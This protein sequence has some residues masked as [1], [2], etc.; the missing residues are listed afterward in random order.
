ME[1]IDLF[2][3]EEKIVFNILVERFH[4]TAVPGLQENI[5]EY[6]KLI[7]D[8]AAALRQ[9]GMLTHR[10]RQIKTK[11]D[12][13]KVCLKEGWDDLLKDMEVLENA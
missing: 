5:E 9:N 7:K 6:K 4:D 13:I 2:K 12:L 10:G 8:Y 1:L 3:E 11:P